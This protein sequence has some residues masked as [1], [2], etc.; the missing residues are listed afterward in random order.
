MT[1]DKKRAAIRNRVIAFPR[2][3]PTQE[4]VAAIFKRLHDLLLLTHSKRIVLAYSG[5]LDSSV[6]LDLLWC[7]VREREP[8]LEL[9]A[10]HVNHGI[11]SDA[12]YWQAAC[13]SRAVQLGVVLVTERIEISHTANIEAVARAHRYRVLRRHLDANSMLC[14]AHH[15]DDQ[16]ETLLLHLLRGAGPAGLSAMKSILRF[17]PGWLARP[18]LDQARDTICAYAR[19]RGIDWAEDESNYNADYSR[20]Y[21]RHRI[22][23]LLKAKW[24]G[25]DATLA[26]ATRHQSVAQ[27][28]LES[29]SHRWLGRCLVGKMLSCKACRAVPA[30]RRSLVLR[31]W[32]ASH[33]VAIPA[34]RKIAALWRNLIANDVQNGAALEWSGVAFRFYRG[35]LYLVKMPEYKTPQDEIRWQ[36]GADIKLPELGMTLY[37]RDLVRQAPELEKADV[38]LRFRVGNE[39][40]EYDGGCHHRS[41]KKLFQQNGVPPWER[42]NIPLIYADDKLRLVWNVASCK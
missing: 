3:A 2:S 9:L 33:A 5:G 39:H 14:T 12:D 13:R 16:A 28:T 7:F 19:A 11:S 35:L 32:I 4:L 6:L 40:C 41:L 34:E 42:K 18:L 38:S 17:A 8:S 26:R 24:P 29:E 27:A 37:W 22:M 36:C 20:N 1:S 25:C 23:P 21:I 15:R 30:A 10:V 31:A